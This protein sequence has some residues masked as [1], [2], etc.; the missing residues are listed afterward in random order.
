MLLGFTHF[1]VDKVKND[2]NFRTQIS[3]EERLAV[4]IMTVNGLNTNRSAIKVV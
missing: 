1:L 2:Q 4:R 3:T